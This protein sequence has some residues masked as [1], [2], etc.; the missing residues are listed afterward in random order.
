MQVGFICSLIFGTLATGLRH[1]LVKSFVV[2]VY[3]KSRVIQGEMIVNT[4]L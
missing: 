2:D 4:F 1:Q 3:V